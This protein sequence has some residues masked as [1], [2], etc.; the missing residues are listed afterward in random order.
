MLPTARTANRA[1]QL[2]QNGGERVHDASGFVIFAAF[3]GLLLLTV[4]V[5]RKRCGAPI[6]RA[7]G[8]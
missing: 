4:N 7:C 3:L 8:G 6:S 1:S 2:G 5:L